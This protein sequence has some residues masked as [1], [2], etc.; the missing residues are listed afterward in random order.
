VVEFPAV[1]VIDDFNRADEGPPPTGWTNWFNDG[2]VV[3]GNQLAPNNT[4]YAGIYYSAQS[5]GPNLDAYIE[6]PVLPT[7]SG[8][9]LMPFRYDV[10]TDTGYQLSYSRGDWLSIMT[11]NGGSGQSNIVVVGSPVFSNGD[12]L[13]VRCSGSLIQAWV[14]IGGIWRVHVQAVDSTYPGNLTDRIAFWTNGNFSSQMRLDNFA[15]GVTPTAPF[16]RPIRVNS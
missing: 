14:R 5:F 1:S 3:S 4:L 15:A 9:L 11:R 7:A 8:A 12:A 6:I 13:G 2:F 16:I 10:A